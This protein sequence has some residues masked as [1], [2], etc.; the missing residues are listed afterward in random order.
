MLYGNPRS[1]VVMALAL[2]GMAA[3]ASAALA[4]AE[5]EGEAGVPVQTVEVETLPPQELRAGECGLF[6]WTNSSE[7]RLVFASFSGGAAR[8]RV[9]GQDVSL[10]RNAAEGS[11]VLG[12]FESQNFYSPE[13]NVALSM[14]VERRPNV[15]DGA[16][17]PSATLRVTETSG[18]ETVIPVGGLIGCGAA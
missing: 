4:A 8:M 5:G 14:E 17:V 6:L 3:S 13:M 12:Q 2:A 10:A 18:W 15:V 7:P 16:V 11:E 9:N 1:L